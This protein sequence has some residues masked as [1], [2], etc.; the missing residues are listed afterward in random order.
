MPLELEE[1]LPTNR[2]APAPA[3][4]KLAA[5]SEP[6]GNLALR[7]AVLHRG[8][9]LT[10]EDHRM[11]L[12]RDHV[13][14]EDALASAAVLAKGQDHGDPPVGAVQCREPAGY[15]A[16]REPDLHA[17]APRARAAAEE[18]VRS[19]GDDG[20]VGATLDRRYVN[21]VLLDDLA[22]PDQSSAG[23]S[24]SY[25][26]WPPAA[27]QGSLAARERYE[28]DAILNECGSRHPFNH[29]MAVSTLCWSW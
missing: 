10:D 19:R 20:G 16:L 13:A 6:A 11:N 23:S 5:D 24:S 14:W 18:V 3:V 29:R 15:P 7:L 2:K 12:S 4:E 8:D 27:P 17:A 25:A 9:R 28:R 1:V 21:H 26:E 22:E